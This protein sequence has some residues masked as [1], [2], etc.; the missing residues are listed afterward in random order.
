M[1]GHY[2]DGDFFFTHVLGVNPGYLKYVAEAT[3]KKKYYEL[4]NELI[5]EGA[6]FPNFDTLS[7]EDG[8]EDLYK[9]KIVTNRDLAELVNLDRLASLMMGYKCHWLLF[10]DDEGNFTVDLADVDYT[11][12]NPEPK[13][14]FVGDSVNFKNGETG[15]IEDYNDKY[16][17]IRDNNLRLHKIKR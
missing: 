9:N 14:Y 5:E 4:V 15:I 16:V 1:Y 7:V 13:T 11:E 6:V 3:D 2:N 12:A 17:Y 8:I 10:I